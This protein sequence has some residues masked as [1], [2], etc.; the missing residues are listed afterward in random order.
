MESMKAS[1]DVVARLR[2]DV[3]EVSSAEKALARKSKED[4]L[5][6]GA[7]S[8]TPRNFWVG[9]TFLPCLLSCPWSIY[10]RADCG[11]GIASDG[12]VLYTINMIVR[13]AYV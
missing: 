13:R 3:V 2:P 1:N 8:Q 5:P 4:F 10:V 12:M 9:K 6:R 11:D 7:N